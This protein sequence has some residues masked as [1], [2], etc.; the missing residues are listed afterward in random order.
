M[1]I[2]TSSQASGVKLSGHNSASCVVKMN[3]DGTVS[4]MTGATD[5]GQGSSTIIAQIVAEVLG[6][7]M[8]DVI[9]NA[10]IDNDF[11][12]IDPGTYGSRV[13]FFS[14]NAAKIAAADAKRQLTEVAS[15]VMEVLPEEIIFK[16]RKVFQKGSPDRGW[17]IDTLIRYVQHQMG[18]HSKSILGRG[19]YDAGIDFIDFKT[20][21]GNISPAYTFAAD[22]VEVE[23]DPETGKVTILNLC[24]A[25]DI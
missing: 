24:G 10:G 14:G 17:K 22:V 18:K 12:P 13:S 23:V 6:L 4:V 19:S 15:K 7:S 3:E 5:V 21:K 1:G 25:H 8:G 9:I 20:G 16:D 2:G 11:T